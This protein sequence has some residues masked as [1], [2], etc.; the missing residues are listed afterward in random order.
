MNS[1]RRKLYGALCAAMLT[2][3]SMAAAPPASAS[4]ASTYKAD[5]TA[6][7][8]TALMQIKA[9]APPSTADQLLPYL[10]SSLA[11]A[12]QEIADLQRLRPPAHDKAAFRAA[13]R[14][15]RRESAIFSAYAHKLAAGTAKPKDFSKV[16][17]Q[18]SRIDKTVN[19][20]FRRAGLTECAK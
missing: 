10:R 9:L 6:I 14:G 12:Q 7:C 16:D 5:G 18:I 15:A 13:L 11:L 8:K 4:V 3:A 20:D 17:K 19:R 1:I 2:G